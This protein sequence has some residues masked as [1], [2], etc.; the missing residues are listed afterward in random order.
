MNNWIIVSYNEEIPPDE[1]FPFTEILHGHFGKVPLTIDVIKDY[2]KSFYE[3]NVI[4]S[5]HLTKDKY[6]RNWT[7]HE[8]Y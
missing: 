8:V 7:R 1:D 3:N 2:L 4:L 5:I 6:V